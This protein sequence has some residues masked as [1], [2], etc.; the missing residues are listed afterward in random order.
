MKLKFEPKDFEDFQLAEG[1]FTLG[2][3]DQLAVARF[4]N[5]L[6][7]T[8]LSLLVNERRLCPRCNTEEI[9]DRSGTWCACD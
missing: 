6:L 3:E 7:H 2:A 1:R 5:L 9:T 8:K 4:C